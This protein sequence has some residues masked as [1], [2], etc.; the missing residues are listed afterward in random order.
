[1]DE[2]TLTI[3]DRE[4]TVPRD[5]TILTAAKQAGIHIPTL[6]HLEEL[7]PASVCRICLVEVEGARTLVTAC[8]HPV[9]PGMKVKT[10]TDR[11]LES[12]RMVLELILSDHPLDCMTCEK[13]GNCQL[14][15]LAYSMGMTG[16]QF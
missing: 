13:T 3:D 16:S 10:R 12:R 5:S 2:V 11:V 6:C 14:Q 7:I 4:V 1:M 8:S 9:S 15:D